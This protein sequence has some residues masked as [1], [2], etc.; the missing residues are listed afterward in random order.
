MKIIFLDNSNTTKIDEEVLRVMECY[1]TE[2]YGVPGGEFGH[3]FE[4]EAYE[5]LEKSREVIAG[6]IKANPEEIVFT[7]GDL[8]SNNLA[9]SGYLNENR[10]KG[11]KEKIVTSKIEQKSVLEPFKMFENYGYI[12]HYTGVDSEGFLNIEEFEEQAKNAAFASIQHSNREIGT[13][14]DIK[15]I[16]DICGDIG[17]ILHSDASHSFC[18]TEL[19]VN[20]INVDLMTLS[21][22]LI[23]G[24]KG[25]GALFVREGVKLN[26]ILHGD[27][28]EKGIRPGFID[29]PSAIGFAKAVELY[30]NEDIER[31]KRLRDYL[32][33]KLLEI[34]DSELNGPRQRR[35]CNNVNVSF[36]YVEGEAI[37]LHA[38]MN[39]LVIGT[40]SA[41]YSQ[42][43]EPSHVILSLGKGYD[44]GHS[45]TRIT[46]SRFTTEDEV[47]KAAEII[48]EA[49]ENLRI[50]SPFGKC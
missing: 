42:K 8:E 21:S 5:A 47:E 48:G 26:P 31:M 3:L 35:L 39:G 30:R 33:D 6:K 36:R 2:K 24:P 16:G 12:T 45:S 38:N 34:K 27:F 1:M 40:G 9:I 44:M 15:A 20:K 43:L 22:N 18:K 11:E 19:D 25:I 13:I 14:Q 50:L 46:L 17:V 28:R 37:V 32:I 4:E 41:C 7:S 10:A 23:H 29:V 49:I